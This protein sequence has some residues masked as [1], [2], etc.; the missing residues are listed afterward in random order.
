M[1][2]FHEKFKKEI[3]NRISDGYI[4]TKAL[5]SYFLNLYFKLDYG[6]ERDFIC[7]N[8]ND[9]GIDAIFVDDNAE[10]ICFI[11]SKFTP[12]NSDIDMSHFSSKFIGDKEPKEFLGSV[13]Q[14]TT[15]EKVEMLYNSNNTNLEVKRLIHDY[16]IAEKVESYTLRKI[17]VTNRTKGSHTTDIE[18]HTDI[19]F[20]TPIELEVEHKKYFSII[21]E[22][23]PQI[24][25]D[26]TPVSNIIRT[27]NE[28]LICEIKTKDLIE[29]DGIDDFSVFSKNVRSWLGKNRVY[30]S[31]K[32]NLQD[33]KFEQDNNILFHNGITILCNTIS[34]NEDTNEIHLTK[35]SIVNGCQSTFAFFD[36]KNLILENHTVL[37]KIIPQKENDIQLGKQIVYFSNNQS[38]VK[39]SDLASLSDNAKYIETLFNS[40][41]TWCI[42]IRAGKDKNNCQNKKVISL[43]ELAQYIAS[44]Y[45]LG[46]IL[47]SNKNKLLET[48]FYEVFNSNLLYENYKIVLYISTVIDNVLKEEKEKFSES[49]QKL[50]STYFLTK[51]FILS[52]LKMIFEDIHNKKILEIKDNIEYIFSENY[53]SRLEYQIKSFII[54]IESYLE[55]NELL[56]EYKRVLK[57]NEDSLKLLS[58]IKKAY[59]KDIM[60]DPLYTLDF[61]EMVE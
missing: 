48:S 60:K 37:V 10:E 6:D 43:A 52:V 35:L 15:K 56:I 23:E 2:E 39:A 17:F 20:F 51:L 54:E 8:M 11:Q 42:K 24:D 53:K 4:E 25:F 18:N 50:L 7:D 3:D 19:E 36:N 44:F 55:E 30:K 14:F 26:F 29:L 9:R 59:Q 34:Y 32:D 45:N 33:S 57:N 27:S 38:H 40:D 28:T 16:N 5:I 61:V 31:I 1:N 49:I 46:H 13:E 58:H 47:A 21:N 22:V 12:I 41:D